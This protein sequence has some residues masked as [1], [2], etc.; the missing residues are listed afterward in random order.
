MNGWVVDGN[1]GE[2][3]GEFSESAQPSGWFRTYTGREQ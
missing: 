2:Y 1:M 3:M